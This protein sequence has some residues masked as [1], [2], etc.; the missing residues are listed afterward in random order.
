MHFMDAATMTCWSNDYDFESAFERQ[1]RTFCQ[2][3]DLLFGFSTSGNSKNVVRALKAAR[4]LGATTIALTGESGG[5]LKDI[6][7]LCLQAPSKVTERVQEVHITFVH[8]LI[9]V[10][11]KEL[12]S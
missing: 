1:A 5:A 2:P 11:E 9:E 8:T 7:H 4:E 6:A 3:G 10:V 12:F